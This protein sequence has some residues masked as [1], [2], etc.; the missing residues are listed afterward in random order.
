ME[1][2]YNRLVEDNKRAVE[3]ISKEIMRAKGRVDAYAAEADKV[4]MENEHLREPLADV[5]VRLEDAKGR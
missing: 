5:L 3:T 4:V 2:C 1:V